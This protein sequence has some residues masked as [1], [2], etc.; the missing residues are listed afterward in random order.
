MDAA[1]ALILIAKIKRGKEVKY[2]CVVG[3]LGVMLPS[4]LA[5]RREESTHTHEC[6]QAH[7]NNISLS[8]YL[9]K[10]NL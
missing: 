7:Q 3:S 5:I 1:N 6:T 8:I 2:R 9:I 4:K 10:R